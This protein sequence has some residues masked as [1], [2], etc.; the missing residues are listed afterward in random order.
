MKMKK[1]YAIEKKRMSSNILDKVS[2]AILSWLLL[3]LN[4][5]IGHYSFTATS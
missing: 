2:V 5:I 4:F 3:K 1:E